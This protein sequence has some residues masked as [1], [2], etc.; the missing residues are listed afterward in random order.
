MPPPTSSQPD[1]RPRSRPPLRAPP[2]PTLAELRRAR[3]HL[4]RGRDRRDDDDLFSRRG[5][6][7]QA[8]SGDAC[9][10]PHL[11][12]R[13]EPRRVALPL[14]LVPPIQGSPRAVAHPYRPRGIRHHA[15]ER[16]DHRRRA[17]QRR[18]QRERQ[19]LQDVRRHA[20]ARPLFSA[21]GGRLPRRR[22]ASGR[23]R[24]PRFWERRLAGDTSAVGRTDPRERARIHCRRRRATRDVVRAVVHQ[25]GSVDAHRHVCGHE[26]GSAARFARLQHVPGHRPARRWRLATVRRARA[27]SNREADRGGPSGDDQRPRRGPVPVFR[28]A[29]GGTKRRDAF[30]GAPHELLAADPARGVRQSRRRDHGAR[31]AA[32]ARAGRAG[33]ARRRPRHGSAAARHRNGRAVPRRMCRRDRHRHASRRMPSPRSSRRSKC[34]ST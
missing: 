11:R 14:V 15:A 19:L 12:V 17:A 3:D 29:A 18:L 8:R 30:L 34:R 6:A 31:S 27:R 25:G 16:R 9:R 10:S 4:H 28:D 33:G 26:A 23:H 7:P 2:T 21:R 24:Q 1:G 5:A 32:A 22:I 13:D 20:G